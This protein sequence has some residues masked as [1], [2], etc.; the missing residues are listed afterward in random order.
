MTV[1][2]LPLP[3][4]L[5]NL[6]LA[7]W[8]V[9]VQMETAF[10]TSVSASATTIAEERRQLIDRPERT[11][12]L[13]FLELTKDSAN[14]L[15]M[16]IIRYANERLP[17]PLYQDQMTTTA[18][19]TA[20]VINVVPLLRR[21]FSGA[22]VVIFDLGTD[23]QPDQ[24]EYATILTVNPTTI[25]LSTTLVNT[26]AA[27][28]FVFPVM[29]IEV[30]LDSSAGVLPTDQMF[31]VSLTVSEKLGSSSLDVLVDGNPSGFPTYLGHP[32]LNIN[33]DWKSSI[34]PSVV[35]GG[36][37]YGQGRGLVV[38][39][40]GDRP[41][42]SYDMS[43]LTLNRSDSWD[44]LNFFES[45]AGRRRPW[46]FTSPHTL[47]EIFAINTAYVDVEVS[48][49][50]EDVQDFVPF[51][52][53]VE[54][55]GTVTIRGVASVTLVSGKWRLTF[56]TTITAPALADIERVTSAHLV[57]Q[58]K[59]FFKESWI[60]D[61]HCEFRVES[62]D[63]LQEKTALIAAVTPPAFDLGPIADIPD[64]Y[65][66]V[67]AS[68]NAWY[69]LSGGPVEP[70]APSIPY[71]QVTH[72]NQVGRIDFLFDCRQDPDDPSLTEPYLQG[73][74]GGGG[75]DQ[76]WLAYFPLH[77]DN[78]GERTIYH[79]G[80]DE[81]VGFDLKNSD[82]P[83]W[84]DTDG[85]TVFVCAR[86]GGPTAV[87]GSEEHRHL[88]RVGIFEWK[89]DDTSGKV[90]FFAT[91]DATVAAANITYIEPITS[92]LEIMAVRWDPGV[93]AELFIGGGA[94]LA[95]ATTP[96]SSIDATARSTEVLT[97]E[98][99]SFGFGQG[100]AQQI[101]HNIERQCMSNH[102]SIYKRALTDAEMDIVGQQLADKYN[103][104]WE[105][106]T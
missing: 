99:N 103:L 82:D 74:T 59:D 60:T 7:D 15:W 3:S 67:E 12:T 14:R 86:F 52:A 26:Y 104:T 9:Q 64:L 79:F 87:G 77:R 80:I 13:T 92:D 44:V 84:D 20:T 63:L 81:D 31:E 101:D 96:V 43:I 51:V 23:G 45:R 90:N 34:T 4:P 5:P 97:Y 102:L 89:S 1:T 70:F 61:E 98:S 46:W 66:W 39:P 17:L 29:D 88:S 56:D 16:N 83:F 8:R 49:N 75:K 54:K 65:L 85:L 55:D 58:R 41:R 6:F 72:S 78:S 25:G 2:A 18:S 21:V 68:G 32:V 69:D 71:P 19:S 53:I 76:P 35:G 11:L 48:G 47:F 95:T 50:I 28:A 91:A 30:D 24:I 38:K 10:Q 42:L 57:R 73:F 106:V 62:M 27:G 33:P 94:A 100:H 105:P 40:Q 22:R 37:S 36:K 93:S